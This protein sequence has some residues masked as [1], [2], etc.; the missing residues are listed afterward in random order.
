[1]HWRRFATKDIPSNDEKAFSAWLLER[2]REKDDLLEHYLTYGDFPADEGT[3]PSLNGAKPLKGAG[4]I[5]TEVRP[6]TPLE[7]L[8][9]IIP[10]AAFGLVVNVI[11]KFVNMVLRILHLK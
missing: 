4:V 9:I 6:Q 1:M 7:F 5:E 8:K 2:W 3:T 11:L 10:P